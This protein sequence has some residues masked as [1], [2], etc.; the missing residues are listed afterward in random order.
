MAVKPA[1]QPVQQSA[2][3]QAKPVNTPVASPPPTA[4][5]I[6]VQ[7]KPAPTIQPTQEMPKMQGLE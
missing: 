4:A 1:Q 5:P 6:V 7:A 3:V 2:A